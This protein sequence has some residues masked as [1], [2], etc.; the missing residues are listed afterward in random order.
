MKKPGCRRRR[1]SPAATQNPAGIADRERS[2]VA[3]IPAGSR[4][5]GSGLRGTAQP[6]LST[7]EQA[8]ESPSVA[9]L[10][11]MKTDPA[12]CRTDRVATAEL[13]PGDSSSRLPKGR[14]S[15]A[16]E[17]DSL[18][19]GWLGATERRTPPWPTEG[20]REGRG[21]G[22]PASVETG[23]G[24]FGNRRSRPAGDFRAEFDC[25]VSF[26]SVAG[27]LTATV[28]HSFSSTAFPAVEVTRHLHG[29]WCTQC[30]RKAG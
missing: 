5:S 11:G 25:P 17:C 27:R 3:G 1:W 21:R 7:A 8:G 29:G 24:R 2:P 4:L 14:P 13:P 15:G 20:K 23:Q 6:V 22:I 12:H 28:T 30:G 26:Q 10:G 9:W 18:R 19:V 16:G